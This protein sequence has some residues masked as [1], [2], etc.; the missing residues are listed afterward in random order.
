MHYAYRFRSLLAR[1]SE[2]ALLFRHRARIL[3]DDYEEV[4]YV[5]RDQRGRTLVRGHL[6]P[7][8]QQCPP[9]AAAL[10]DA[11][12]HCEQAEREAVETEAAITRVHSLTSQLE[13]PAQRA[14]RETINAEELAALA[15]DR[16]RTGETHAHA[17]SAQITVLG[18][19]PI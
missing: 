8:V 16:A 18:S 6:I 7:Q 9:V 2:A 14:T 11:C 15:T 5:W 1:I 3:E 4:A 17:L 13:L 12:R 19:P 10:T